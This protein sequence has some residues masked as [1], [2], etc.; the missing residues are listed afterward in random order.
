MSSAYMATTRTLSRHQH[1]NEYVRTVSSKDLHLALDIQ[2][3]GSHLHISGLSLT[4]HHDQVEASSM[5]IQMPGIDGPLPQLSS[6]KFAFQVAQPGT[7]IDM[8]GRQSVVFDK[9]VW[10]LCWSDGAP[11]G[12]LLCGFTVSQDYARNEACLSSGQNYFCTFP[13]FSAEGLASLQAD[14]EYMMKEVNALMKTRQDAIDKMRS[15]FNP[16]IKAAE[17]SKAMDA[18]ERLS[19]YDM[20]RLQLIPSDKEVVPICDSM[21]ISNTGQV[22]S[23]GV[24][25]ER[26]VHGSAFVK[27]RDGPV[28]AP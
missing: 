12:S 22:W 19:Y 1:L 20:E 28:L 13:V 6:G 27:F 26:V 11:S 14:K 2:K 7:Y 21:M 17:Y 4:L 23:R 15:T 25:G 18:L 16:I 10:E 5:D 8:K 24:D 9:S 3:N